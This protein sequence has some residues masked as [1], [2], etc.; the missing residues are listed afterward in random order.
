[1]TGGFG[2]GTGDFEQGTGAPAG[3]TPV[4]RRNR[5]RRWFTYAIS[6]ATILVATPVA[7]AD[8]AGPLIDAHSH[9]PDARAIEAYVA[10]MQRNNVSKVL[11][12]GVGGIQK[13]DPAFIAAAVKKHPDRVIP[14][15]PLPDPQSE[16]AAAR[17]DA[18]L[19]RGSARA[20]G[21]V[22]VRQVS[23][24]IDRDPSGPAFLKILGVAGR[25]KVPV[26]IHQ[27]LNDR[28]AGAL[29][30]ALQAAPAATIVLAH[31]GESGPQQLD[32][33]LARNPNLM[34]DLSGM[35]FERKPRL[36][37]ED[38]PLDPAWKALIER[39]PER[40][41]MGMDVWSPRLFEPAMLDRLMRWTRRILGELR[42]DVAEQVAYANAARLYGVK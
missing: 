32:G 23:R 20:I 38:G 14:G 40:F 15:L 12:L 1:M 9:V 24:K 2:Q 7:A 41:V 25:R 18:E 31:A 19:A 5:G 28:A 34:V 10:A 16:A 30:R 35:H 26:V 36:A 3:A 11:L 27:D 6:V 29:E 13:S 21:E 37:T 39:R 22:H 33:L 42:P 4:P 8:Y 17:I